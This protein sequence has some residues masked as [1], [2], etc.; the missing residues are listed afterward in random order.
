[1]KKTM[2]LL[3]MV[4]L[5]ILMVCSACNSSPGESEEVNNGAEEEAPAGDNGEGAEET[6]P[7]ATAMRRIN[8]FATGI[9]NLEAQE[10][11]DKD[12]TIS[13]YAVQE[14]IDSNFAA[15]PVDPVVMVATDGYM[16][17]TQVDEFIKH[18]ITLEGEY[19]PLLAGPDLAG[20]L[21][22]KYLQYIKTAGESICFV[23]ETLNVGDIFSTLGMVEADSYTFVATDGFSFDVAAADIGDCILYRNEA[24]VNGTLTG[25]TGGDMRDVLYIEAKQ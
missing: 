5:C 23:E 2:V 16:A 6:P 24:S 20:E 9:L 4:V 1:M 13:A 17:S 3:F 15:A 22:V 12:G 25:L 21:R 7:E 10:V 18:Y 19:A 14:Y 8:I 11:N